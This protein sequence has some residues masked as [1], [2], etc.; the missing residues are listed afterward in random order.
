MGNVVPPSMAMQVSGSGS[1]SGQDALY[2]GDLQWWTSDEDIRQVALN[3]G[4]N[5]DHKHITFSEHKVN[6]KS[7]G[8]SWVECGSEDAA[9]TLKA[10]FDSND[11]QNRRATATLSASSTGNP[12]RTLP[13]D[14]PPREGRQFTNPSNSSTGH[15]GGGGG[16]GGGRGSYRGGHN[17]M[18]GR[19]GLNSNMNAMRGGQSNMMGMG[20]MP[21]MTN[22]GAMGMGGGM[23]MG[24]MGMMGGMPANGM[25]MGMGMPANMGH[26][27]GAQQMHMRGGMIPQ[28][29][30]GGG[31]MGRGMGGGY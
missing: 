16:G 30:R 17:N 2:L 10:W 14:P 5:I 18:G 6:G 31:M 12:F 8:V 29:A 1:G 23:G 11:F 20:N 7:K 15:S 21:N 25:N 9:A 26:F 24:G 4:V 13:K 22:I 3:V 28:G 27:G 19:G